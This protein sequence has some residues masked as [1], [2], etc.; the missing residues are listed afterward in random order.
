M[1]SLIERLRHCTLADLTGFRP[2]SIEGHEIGWLRLDVAEA[3][4][5]FPSVFLVTEDTVSVQSHLNSFDYR[6]AAIG[7]VARALLEM[8]VIH[9][10]RNEAFAVAAQ[11]GDAPLLRL[12][13]AA[14]P[15]FGVKAYGVHL[16]GY[17]R[18]PAGLKL[19]I[20]RRADN[21]PVEPG[22]LDNIVAGGLPYGLDPL[23][24]LIK[25]CAEEAGITEDLARRSR[26]VG[27]IS[28][29]MLHQ[30]FLRQDTLFVYDLELPADFQPA[31]VDGEIADFRLMSLAEVTAIL[32]DSEAFKFNVAPVVI[33]FLIR[34][35]HLTPDAPGY[36]DLAMG[37][38]V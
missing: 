2:W 29:R 16:N 30:G 31:N 12:E 19:W 20:G 14:V 1:M 3:L 9:G 8:G 21:R 37:L 26:P 15:V 22:K 18:T 13:R 28:Y 25:E 24:N 17:V 35:G 7:E 33:D 34:H 23:H 27:A 32:A 5:R 11:Y 36:V 4:R 6:S 38:S 10:W